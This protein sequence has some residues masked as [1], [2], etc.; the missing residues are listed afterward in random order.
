ME[1][2]RRAS[3]SFSPLHRGGKGIASLPQRC[4]GR[5][6]FWSEELCDIERC[7]ADRP[8]LPLNKEGKGIG[9]VAATGQ[10]TAA[11]LGRKTSGCRKVFGPPPLAPP[12]QEGERN[13]WCSCDRFNERPRYWGE[14]L[15]VS[16]GPA[17]PPPPSQGGKEWAVLPFGWREQDLRFVTKRKAAQTTHQ[18]SPGYRRTS[19][20]ERP[21]YR[22]GSGGDWPA[23]SASQIGCAGRPCILPA[24]PPATRIGRFTW[25]CTF[26]LPIP[27]P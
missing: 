8:C 15:A 21:P 24:A 18:P 27:L 17:A 23:A 13:G 1:N 6:R 7:W 19:Q 4:N 12:A 3:L 26:G 20:G 16:K 14:K 22:A 2:Q 9:G 25:S 10:R 11:S 5:P